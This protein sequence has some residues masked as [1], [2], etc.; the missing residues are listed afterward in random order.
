MTTT[1]LI[2]TDEDETATAMKTVSR[3]L[4]ATEVALMIGVLGNR[5]RNSVAENAAREKRTPHR[6]AIS[7]MGR[8]AVTRGS[9]RAYSDVVCTCE[10]ME[11]WVGVGWSMELLTHTTFH[12]V[13][14]V[15]PFCD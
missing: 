9:T 11:R 1:M 12:P 10:I 13:P 6:T 4:A 8:G 5:P 2:G 3:L 7:L 14:L 15:P